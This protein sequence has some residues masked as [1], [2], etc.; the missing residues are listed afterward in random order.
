[1]EVQPSPQSDRRALQAPAGAP[2]ALPPAG[3]G[4]VSAGPLMIFEPAPDVVFR[5]LRGEAVILHL[6]TATYF[7]LDEVGTRAWQLIVEKRT[8]AD[9]SIQLAEEF[10]APAERIESDV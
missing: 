9:V 7:G 2:C 6:G 8:I 1:R 4:G 5:E 10:D 3:R